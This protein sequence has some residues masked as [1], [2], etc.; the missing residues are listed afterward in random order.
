MTY[1][2]IAADL[3][4]KLENDLER[5]TRAAHIHEIIGDIL[6]DHVGKKLTKRF[7]DK[8]TAAICA[9]WDWKP[10]CHYEHPGRLAVWD[11]KTIPYNQRHLFYIA[12]LCES[13]YNP[14]H[15]VASP[16]LEGFEQEDRCN[17]QDA[18]LRN[19]ERRE[20]LT[21]DNI[22]LH[23]IVERIVELRLKRARLDEILEPLTCG[24]QYY[25]EGLVKV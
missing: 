15:T 4:Q 22:R 21:P 20:L 17:G 25:V 13:S 14:G 6:K 3:R 12:P 18:Q 8:V 7:T 9:R 5:E 11:H 2:D 19:T 23:T 24:I 1:N 16:T 10:I